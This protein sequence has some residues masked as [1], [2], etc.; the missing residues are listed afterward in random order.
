MP[1]VEILSVLLGLSAVDKFYVQL[2]ARGGEHIFCEISPFYGGL[3][4]VVTFYQ[5]SSPAFSCADVAARLE[6]LE[7]SAFVFSLSC[8]H[9][10]MSSRYSILSAKS[11]LEA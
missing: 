9:P 4:V 6:Y 11:S 2:L 5:Y 3:L 10:C 8:G 7:C 1:L